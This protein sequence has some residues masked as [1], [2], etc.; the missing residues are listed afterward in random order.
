MSWIANYFG[1]GC[2]KEF[3]ELVIVFHQFGS[4]CGKEFNGL[5]IVFH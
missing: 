1:N 2:G 4:G 5:V 3:N